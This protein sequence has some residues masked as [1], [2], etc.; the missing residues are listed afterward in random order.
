MEAARQASTRAMKLSEGATNNWND[1]IKDKKYDFVP[2]TT[3][4]SQDSSAPAAT[5][6]CAQKSVKE[7]SLKRQREIERPES[8]Q[9]RTTKEAKAGH[10]N[11]PQRKKTQSPKKIAIK[12]KNR[13]NS[14]SSAGYGSLVS[15]RTHREVH[16]SQDAMDVDVSNLGLFTKKDTLTPQ[17]KR[18]LMAAL[19]ADPTYVE[20]T[21]ADRSRVSNEVNT[22]K[23]RQ[24]TRTNLDGRRRDHQRRSQS[25]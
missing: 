2:A 22:L 1:I 25:R 6:L 19:N 23:P 21:R 17:S 11:K 24:A 4:T 20:R 14:R 13:V 9:A 3:Q 15:A 18:L 16:V 8:T 7:T 5:A 12:V 10:K